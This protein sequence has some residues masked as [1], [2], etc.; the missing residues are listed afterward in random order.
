MSFSEQVLA[1]ILAKARRVKLEMILVGNAAAALH[2][3]PV[4]TQDVDFFVRHTPM[5]L[6]KLRVLA[7]EL[8]GM[9]TQPYY[10]T[11]RM[12]R[13]VAPDFSVDFVFELSSRRRFESVRSRAARMKIGAQAIVVASLEDVIAAKEAAARPKDRATLRILKETL[14]TQKELENE[15]K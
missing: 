12:M 13:V 2:K 5:N 9:L 14:R 10:P 1:Q 15:T 6:K 4:M 7:D 11:S 3:V 8:G